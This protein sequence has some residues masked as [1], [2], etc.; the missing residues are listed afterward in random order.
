MGVRLQVSRL[1]CISTNH[2]TLNLVGL[3]GKGRIHMI[4]TIIIIAVIWIIVK[5]CK[6]DKHDEEADTAAIEQL[7]PFT[8]RGKK[9]SGWDKFLNLA[10]DDNSVLKVFSYRDG[11]VYITM[12]NG[13]T[14][15]SPLRELSVAF[16]D[17]KGCVVFTLE[18]A[19]GANIEFVQ[20]TN[21]DDK[22]WEAITS[23]LCLASTTY[24]KGIFSSSYKNLGKV[25]SALKAIKFLSSY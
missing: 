16:Q 15:S 20:Q 23:T 7:P 21:F 9:M 8:V 19:K 17:M 5:A 12:Q 11:C 25:N 10:Y 3:I 6:K 24:N 14:F 13:K 4:T 18:N 22:Q 2:E 1:S